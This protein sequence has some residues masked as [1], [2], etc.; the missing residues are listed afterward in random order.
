MLAW[1]WSTMNRE[2]EEEICGLRKRMTVIQMQ[3]DAVNNTSGGAGLGIP[4]GLPMD[5]NMGSGIANMQ[6]PM[7]MNYNATD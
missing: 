1:T 7:D 3:N 2:L 5:Q 4:H 6:W